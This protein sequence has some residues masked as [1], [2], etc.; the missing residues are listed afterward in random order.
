MHFCCQAAHHAPN[1]IRNYQTL[2][3]K[4]TELALVASEV[5]CFFE[6][7]DAEKL[8]VSELGLVLLT[9]LLAENVSTKVWTVNM[10]HAHPSFLNSCLCQRSWPYP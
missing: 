7:C 9:A 4:S 6:F 8:G 10:K 2:V 3:K 5:I 1:L